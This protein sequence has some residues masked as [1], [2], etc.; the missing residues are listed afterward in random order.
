MKEPRLRAAPSFV[1]AHTLDG[2]PYVAK[3]TEPYIQF[4]LSE[5][6]RLLLAMFSGR[7]GATARQAKQGYFSL[8]PGT[9]DA[10]EQ[11]RVAKAL[12]DMQAAGVLIDSAADTSRYNARIVA[13][14]VAH[15]PFPREIAQ[16][17][18]DR[19]PLR[20]DSRVLDLAGGPG[21]LAL[22]LAQ[23]SHQVSLMELSRGFLAAA[24]RRAR[25]A[26]LQITPVHDS[27]NRLV[28]HEH[29]YDVMT[30]SQALHWLDDVMV[31]RGVCRLLREGGSF[32]VVHGAMEV[33][34]SHPLAYLL[35]HDSILGRKAPRPFVDEVRPLL[36]RLALLFEALDAPEVERVDPTQPAP[37][38]A[39]QGIA[40]AGV[41]LFSQRRPLGPGYARGF[42]TPQHIA[43]TGL[44]PE[45]F[46]HDLDARCASATRAQF[47][48][49][50]HWAVL[51]FQRGAD[52]AALP[53]LHS[54]PTV[55]IGF[56]GPA[57]P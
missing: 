39:G 46:W 24:G 1:Q 8:H 47:M 38:G 23:V 37:R 12:R 9:A 55:E 56:D 54:V 7:R 30:V 34:G 32:F 43:A 57:E 31:C 28:F 11:R 50:Q 48:G 21:D 27:C 41:S 33:A 25:A 22:A 45:A 35:G 10:A 44:S 51:H 6:E 4:W 13:D 36:R 5:R 40:P 16:L 52:A 29:E 18:I 2:R 14:Y 15:R 42:L 3:D 26:G 53:P 20:R 17:V 19:T 49:T